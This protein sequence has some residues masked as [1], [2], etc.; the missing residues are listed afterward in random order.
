MH[1]RVHAQASSPLR[2]ELRAQAAALEKSGP[3]R[4]RVRLRWKEP[5]VGAALRA[6]AEETS[7][8]RVGTHPRLGPIVLLTALSSA[9][10]AAARDGG[11][12]DAP[13]RFRREGRA[14][15]LL[16]DCTTRASIVIPEGVTL[17]GGHHRII[18]R[19]P[20]GGRFEGAVVRNGGREAHVRDLVIRATELAPIC[21]EPEARELAA[22]ALSNCSGSIVDSHVE[23][24]QRHGRGCDGEGTGIAVHADVTGRDPPS[25]WITGNLVEQF[26][27]RGVLLEGP[28]SANVQLNRVRGADRGAPQEGVRVANGARGSLR[29]NDVRALGHGNRAA[30]SAGFVVSRTPGPVELSGNRVEG[31][32]LGVLLEGAGGTRVEQQVLHTLARA[33]VLIDGRQAPATDNVV[34]HNDIADAPRAVLLVGPQARHNDVAEAADEREGASE[35]HV[36][37][38]H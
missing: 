23:G 33:A 10:V 36:T 30:P 8:M 21:R 26:G 24:V 14:M 12:A 4:V 6:L 18:A 20:E 35:N 19:D 11:A 5:F 34:Q 28:L 22:I 2:T 7:T 3:A 25:V 32:D 13:C 17:D 9:S 1:A 31:A 15:T 38:L 27:A 37:P 29:W 16:A